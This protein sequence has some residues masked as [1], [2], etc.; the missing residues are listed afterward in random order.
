[1]PFR[2]LQGRTESVM[3]SAPPLIAWKYDVKPA[4]GS[5]EV[6]LKW[7]LISRLDWECLFRM[8]NVTLSAASALV[9]MS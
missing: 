8:P 5:D 1:M 2:H 6:R 4:H 7:R 3:V 9:S